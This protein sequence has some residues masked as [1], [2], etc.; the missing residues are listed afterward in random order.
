MNAA[1]SGIL[2]RQ[3]DGPKSALGEC[4][5]WDPARRILSYL[6]Y[7][8]PQAVAF[9][10]LSGRT[11][12]KPL[13]LRAPLGG[14]CLRRS[15]GYFVFNQDGVHLM[16]N[17]FDIV[18]TVFLPHPSFSEA[19]P[20]DVCVDAEGR[21]LV[22]TADR[23]ESRPNAGLFLLSAHGAWHPLV[24][25]LT[26]A[27]GP[28]VSNDGKS[29]YLADS[30]RGLIYRFSVDAQ[31]GVLDDRRVF[32]QV[33]VEEG[34]PDGNAIDAAGCLWSARWAGHAILQYSPDGRE[35]ARF[36]VPARMVTSC[37]FGGDGLR[38]LFITTASD[39]VPNDCGGHL[40]QMTVSGCGSIQPSAVL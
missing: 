34:L 31:S 19:P 7:L 27:N 24:S 20:N 26:V 5:V 33:P 37:A 36:E 8:Q 17:D 14:H 9:D 30:P 28:T 39:D 18:A 2:I 25:G 21:V 35:L 3:I 6:D 29:F 10:E 38:T 15:G 4:P 12:S 22:A 13:P 32:A 40:F 23:L 16:S 1:E 11:I